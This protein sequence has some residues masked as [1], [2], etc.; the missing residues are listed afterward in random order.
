[1]SLCQS[2]KFQKLILQKCFKNTVFITRV[3]EI[4]KQLKVGIFKLEVEMI[5]LY[6]IMNLLENSKMITKRYDYS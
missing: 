5:S 1:M 4:L 6:C 3:L 2:R